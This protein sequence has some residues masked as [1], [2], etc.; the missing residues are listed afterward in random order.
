MSAKAEEISKYWNKY[1]LDSNLK[2][3]IKEWLL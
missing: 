1:G 2:S 3:A